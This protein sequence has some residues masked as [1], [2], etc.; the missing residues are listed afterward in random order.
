NNRLQEPGHPTSRTPLIAREV[1]NHAGGYLNPKHVAFADYFPDTRA[2]HRG[3]RVVDAVAIEKSVERFGN[4]R[5]DP[6]PL[7]EQRG[8]TAR[9]GSKIAAAH[10]DVSG[11]HFINPTRSI[12]GEHLA[13][14]I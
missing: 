12:G 5:G 4:D 3:Q 1:L 11:P 2:F 8:R 14:L 13:D 7:Q 6:E 10:Q 9:A